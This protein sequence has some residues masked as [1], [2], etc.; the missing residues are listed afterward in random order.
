MSSFKGI[1]LFGSGPHRFAPGAR[2]QAMESELFQSPPN[3][4]TRYL[5]PVELEVVATGRLIA[6][7]DAGLGAL[8]TAIT[9]QLLDP[10]APGTLIGAAGEEWDDISFVKFEPADRIDHGRAVSLEYVAR[11]R[12]FREYPQ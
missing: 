3:S 2:G 5:G 6:A 9:D 10:P 12:K 11:F 4:G 7:D 8:V 1:D